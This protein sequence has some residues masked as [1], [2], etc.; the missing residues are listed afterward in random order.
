MNTHDNLLLG[1][2]AL[3][4]DL[5]NAT[6]LVDVCADW[7]TR[8]QIPLAELLIH[9]GLITPVDREN[10]EGNV[11]RKLQ[12][13]GQ[14]VDTS[15]AALLG[16]DLCASLAALNDPEI[17]ESLGD[18]AATVGPLATLPIPSVPLTRDR[19][20]LLH[21]HATGGIGRIWLARDAHIGRN[22]ALKELRREHAGKPA[23]GTRF[24]REAQITG[25][26]EHPGIV[27]VYEL[28]KRPGNQQPFY[29]MRFIQGQTLSAAARGY[30]EQQRK[31]AAAALELRGLLNAFAAV[32]NAVSYAHARGVVHRDLK[33][34]NVILGDFGEV[35]VLDWGLAKVLGRS[36]EKAGVPVVVA[37]ADSACGQTLQGEI[38]GTPAFMAPEQAAGELDRVDQRS[39]VYGL[40]AILYEVLT[41]QAPF[42]GNSAYEVLQIVREKDPEKPRVVCPDVPPALEAI[43]VRALAKEPE[44]RYPSARALGKDVQ[45]WLADEP[46]DAY[47]EP[48][49]ARL[50]RWGRRH[51]TAVAATAAILLVTVVAL[52]CSTVLIAREQ[53]LTERARQAEREQREQAQQSL[54]MACRAVD[55]MLTEV[56]QNRLAELPGMDAVRRE[57]LHKALT[58]YQQFLEQ[59]GEDPYLRLETGRAYRRL[60]A[61]YQM[62]GQPEKG[63]EASMASLDILNRLV[64]EFPER[65]DCQS[66]LAEC[67]KNQ[68]TL[69]DDLG[70][71]AD[72]LAEQRESKKILT[73]LWRQ[74]QENPFYAEALAESDNKLGNALSVMDQRAEAADAYRRALQTYGEL[75]N[76][77]PSKLDY[78]HAQAKVQNNFGLLLVAGRQYKDA[79]AAY[80]E[81][82][83]ILSQLIAQPGAKS[84]TFLELA[85][86]QNNLGRTMA[87]MR[88]LPDAETAYRDAVKILNQLVNDF[89]TRPDYRLELA[90]S[91][92]SLVPVLAGMKQPEHAEKACRQAQDVLRR[93][94]SD[95]PSRPDYRHHLA[96]T[97]TN[98]GILLRDAKK[99][100]E[101]E[102]AYRE[103]V[104]VLSDLAKIPDR[105]SFRKTLA[106]A[107]AELAK[108]LRDRGRMSDAIETSHEVVV[109]WKRLV[110]DFGTNPDYR[111]ELGMSLHEWAVLLTEQGQPTEAR[112]LFEQAIEHQQ[113]ALRLNPQNRDCRQ[114]LG[115]HYRS[116][117]DACLRSRDLAAAAQAARELRRILPEE[118]YAAACL[119]AR[120]TAAVVKQGDLPEQQAKE[121]AQKYGGQAVE[122]LREA[123]Q[124]GIHNLRDI[125][126]NKDLDILRDRPDYRSLVEEIRAAKQSGSK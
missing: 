11:Q 66:E 13:L 119:L 76:R 26:L 21:I 57:L 12:D 101:A 90:N 63:L 95:F 93:L 69:L 48:L 96:C 46:V 2:L 35:I 15:L 1:V 110:E 92:S 97:Y 77:F 53:K 87:T 7:V 58:F 33:G 36:E 51:K 114:A 42:S 20:S 80:R 126:E 102:S 75:A 43:C 98:L 78:R 81:G 88:Q 24:L 65:L 27:P 68:R 18:P 31:G 109:I 82:I 62:L 14:A 118:S 41:G 107:L 74:N 115:D 22:V 117:A 124:K 16:A 25:Q 64:T 60:A 49:P 86:L 4:A 112:R 40:G 30:R 70:R 50:A 73:E 89:P 39:D 47:R 85:I 8:K 52:S 17:S 79:A 23:H 71:Y 94:A 123:V 38:M 111:S 100:E 5:I 125:E 103:A 121:L 61:I 44:N 99:F 106:A 29:T 56:G 116:L 3:K 59:K 37:D 113:S 19:Y 9:R 84:D 104:K 72:A 108:H 55:E 34:D 83:R 105:P 120:C 45:R 91:F 10:L 28:S 6:Q 67:H 54:T 122:L 32:C